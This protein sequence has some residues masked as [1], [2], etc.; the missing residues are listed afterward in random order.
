MKTVLLIAVMVLA[1]SMGDV[2]LT[3]GM[4]QVGDISSIRLRALWATGRNVIGNRNYLAGVFFM[5]VS[6][7][8]FLALLSWADLSFVF[9]AKALVYVTSTLGA[10]WVLK[11]TVTAERWAGIVLICLGVALVSLP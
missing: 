5:A 10:K 1:D 8:S 9:P 4:K 2:F 11:E 3:T 6:F 7:F